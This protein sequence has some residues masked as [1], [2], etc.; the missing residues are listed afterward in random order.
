MQYAVHLNLDSP[1]MNFEKF[2]VLLTCR[3]LTPY[4]SQDYFTN[5]DEQISCRQVV[6]LKVN[7]LGRIKSPSKWNIATAAIMAVIEYG[8][9]MCHTAVRLNDQEPDAMKI[10]TMTYVYLSFTPISG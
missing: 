10:G 9:L 2:C 7:C 8:F 6:C 1:V 3:S 5:R 4:S